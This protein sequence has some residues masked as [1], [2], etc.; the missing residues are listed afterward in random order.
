MLPAC[1]AL[2]RQCHELDLTL[3]VADISEDGPDFHD[4]IATWLLGHTE[5]IAFGEL[6]VEGD[7]LLVDVTVSVPC[8]YLAA[9]EPARVP[10]GTPGNGRPAARCRA[11]GFS[12]PLPPRPAHARPVFQHGAGQFTIVQRRRATRVP[13]PA[14]PARGGALPVLANGPNPCAGAPCR[15]ADNRKGAACCRD[16]TLEVVSPP[17]ET[18]VEALLRSRRSPFLCKVHREE[19]AIIECEVISACGYLADD[20]VSCSL[21]G[22]TRPGGGPA[23][24]QVCSDW[25]DLGPD[26]TGHPG[27]RLVKGARA[28]K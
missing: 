17:G 4:A 25:P 21:H 11:H 16:L 12:G 8:R 26:D 7:W 15:T 5:R 14:A 10:D 28:R 13:L 19:P 3:R 22:R 27:C 20:Q 18:E 2:G 23:K 1:R 6:Y 24:P 9:G